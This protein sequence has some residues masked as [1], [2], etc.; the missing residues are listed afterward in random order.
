MIPPPEMGDVPD[1]TVGVLAPNMK[2]KVVDPETGK[3]LPIG[4]PGEIWVNGPNRCKG[5]YKNPAATKD[6]ITDDGWYKTGDI[7]RVD[8]RGLWYIVDRMKVGKRSLAL[9]T[10]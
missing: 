3:E 8:E 9:R 10:F 1:G 6:S 5:Y 7:G 2:A 4:Q